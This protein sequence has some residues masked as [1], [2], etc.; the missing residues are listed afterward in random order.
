M[1][2]YLASN[3]GET[4][5]SCPPDRPYFD[6]GSGQCLSAATYKLLYGVDPDVQRIDQP[7][8]TLPGRLVWGTF[9]IPQLIVLLIGIAL[10]VLAVYAWVTDK[11]VNITLAGA[12]RS[13]IKRDY[14]R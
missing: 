9:K 14:A 7:L 13:Y 5:G 12:A 1:A 4:A 11:P 6:Q 3:L 10:L 8:D 2:S